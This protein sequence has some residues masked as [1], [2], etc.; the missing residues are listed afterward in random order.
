VS[1]SKLLH[2][3]NQLEQVLEAKEASA[4]GHCYK[5]ILRHHR[6]PTRWNGV[7]LPCGI[8]EVD[9]V[10]APVVA[11]RDQLELPASQGMVRMG[12]LEIGIG[13][14]TMRCS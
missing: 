14:V 10:L 13:N 2:H 12:Y 8:V 4:T 7:Q 6:G 1:S 9:P 11:I 5:W 3:V